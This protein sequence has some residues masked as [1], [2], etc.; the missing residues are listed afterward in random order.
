[1]FDIQIR[2]STFISLLFLLTLQSMVMCQISICCMSQYIAKFIFS[3]TLSCFKQWYIQLFISTSSDKIHLI[4]QCT[5]A[6]FLHYRSVDTYLL[7]IAVCFQNQK[8]GCGCLCVWRWGLGTVVWAYVIAL[9]S[10]LISTTDGA[11]DQNLFYDL[12]W[13]CHCLLPK[14][15]M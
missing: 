6:H 11:I 4:Q 7:S 3:M 2:M 15:V 14:T 13:T 10:K 9:I 1:M 8:V 12:E 5:L